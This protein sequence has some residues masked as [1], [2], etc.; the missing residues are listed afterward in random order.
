MTSQFNAGTTQS[1]S[2]C[3]A[4]YTKYSMRFCICL[5]IKAII[6]R[7]YREMS[8]ISNSF[9]QILEYVFKSNFSPRC[10][11]NKFCNKL[12]CVVRVQRTNSKTGVC[13]DIYGMHRPFIP[14]YIM[15][16]YGNGLCQQD[17][18]TSCHVRVT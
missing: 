8:Q 12:G 1:I 18:T 11:E 10:C 9:E 14:L 5:P 3:I 7:A 17:N 13:L 2:L 4:E 15:F 16:P 6:I